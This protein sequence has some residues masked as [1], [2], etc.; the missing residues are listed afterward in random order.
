MKVA[1]VFGL[2]CLS[3]SAQ[4][5]AP[6]ELAVNPNRPSFANPA[7]TTMPGV[8]ELEFG[9]QRTL[10]ADSSRSDFQSTLLKLGITEDFEVRIGWNGITRNTDPS[11]ESQSGPSDPNLGFTWRFARQDALGADLALSYAH[12]FP[13]ASVEKGIG[14][15]AADDSLVFLASKDFGKLHAD[16]NV[17]QTWVGQLDGPRIKQPG[18]A[19]ALTHPLAGPWGIGAEIYAIGASDAGPRTLATLWN[20]S[21]QVSPRL[22]LDAGFDRGLNQEAARWNYYLGLTYGIGRFMHR[23]N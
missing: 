23:R 15:G 11:G 16:F 10:F 2:M 21:Y 13:R 8:A 9:L 4:D 20:L 1:V 6:D 17:L 12:K 3:L 18:A 19:L 22:V 7:T 14:S 5:K